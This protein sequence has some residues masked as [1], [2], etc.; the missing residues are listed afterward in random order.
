MRIGIHGLDARAAALGQL[1]FHGGYDVLCSDVGTDSTVCDMLIFAGPRGGT[2]E[3]LE[4]LGR[5][6]TGTVIVDAMEGMP[7]L[8]SRRVVRAAITVPK[9]GASV[10]LSGSNTEAVELV[11]KVFRTAGCS[12]IE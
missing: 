10:L 5:I 7:S 11:G 12:V 6:D 9:S 2:A 3:I 1:L 8:L 4:R